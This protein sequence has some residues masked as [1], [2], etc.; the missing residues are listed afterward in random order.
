MTKWKRRIDSAG[1][2]RRREVRHPAARD[3]RARRLPRR[4]APA[5]RCAPQ[6]RAGGAAADDLL[7]RGELP[8]ARRAVRCADGR[9]R[10][11]PSTPPGARP[12]PLGRLLRR[13]RAD[14]G[15]G[16]PPGEPSRACRRI[17]GLAEELDVRDTGTTGHCHT[18]GR[19]AELMARE[20]G[21][22]ARARR[23]RAA[24]PG[25][26][27]DVGKTGVSDRA[28]QQA[29]PARRRR[30]A[31]DPH[32]PRDRRAAARTPRV[33]GPARLGARPSRAPRRQG[34]PVRPA[35]RGD[36]DRGAH[37]G[38][39]GRLRGDD[40]RARLTAPRWARRPPARSCAPAP[41]RSSTRG[42]R[43]RFLSGA[44]PATTPHALLAGVPRAPR[45]SGAATSPRAAAP[46]GWPGGSTAR[47]PASSSADW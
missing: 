21:F 7:R 29:R 42:V 45:R 6:L 32:P 16:A 19:Y 15:G 17:I 38:R 2:H 46:R 20:L 23:A 41:A 24:S 47:T 30:V 5:P 11:A 13:R 36:P 43:R 44:R 9:R 40:R 37:P 26:L 25:V 12:R 18:V 39:R 22:D 4:R 35:R 8:R 27:H 33:R 3:R 10:R 14:A 31:L 1:R 28:D 34:L